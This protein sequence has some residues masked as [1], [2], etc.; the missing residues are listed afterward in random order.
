MSCSHKWRIQ[1][2]WASLVAA[3]PRLTAF[4]VI[5]E[6][7][8]RRHRSNASTAVLIAKEARL[9][10]ALALRAVLWRDTMSRKTTF[11]IC[12]LKVCL[13]VIEPRS[14]IV[15]RTLVVFIYNAGSCREADCIG[16]SASKVI[17]GVLGDTTS[18]SIYIFIPT[19][20]Q[21]DNSGGVEFW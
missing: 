16:P 1:R 14:I 10:E 19:W 17:V 11:E 21:G 4:Y 15:V 20:C 7:T 5:A 2:S 8:S 3:A 6:T 13:D 12:A 18:N 9:A